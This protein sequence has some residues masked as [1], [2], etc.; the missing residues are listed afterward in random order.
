MSAVNDL[1][2]SYF[3]KERVYGYIFTRRFN[4]FL[5]NFYNILKTQLPPIVFNIKFEVQL[6]GQ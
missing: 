4:E 5:I 6:L 2:I 3:D 1:F